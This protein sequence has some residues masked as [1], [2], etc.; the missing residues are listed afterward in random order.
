MI[1]T[2]TITRI[3]LST[4]SFAAPPARSLF[5]ILKP[6][7]RFAASPLEGEKNS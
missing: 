6:L 4:S 2:F 1:H 5:L 3:N 7:C